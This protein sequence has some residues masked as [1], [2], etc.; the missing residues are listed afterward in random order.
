MLYFTVSYPTPD[1]DVV[2]AT[3]MLDHRACLGAL[4]RLR[5]RLG[6]SSAGPGCSSRSASCSGSPPCRG[7]GSR[8]TA[9]LSASSEAAAATLSVRDRGSLHLRRSARR[10]RHG[11]RPG[12]RD[13]HRLRPRPARARALP[14]R[15]HGARAAGRP[16][17]ATCPRSRRSSPSTT[18]GS[19]CPLT[20]IDQSILARGRDAARAGAR[21]SRRR[22]EVCAT[23]GDKYVAHVFFEEHGIPSPRTLAARARCRTTRATRCSS[24]CARASARGTSIAPPTRAELDVLPRATR[25]SSRWCRSCAS[26]RS[27]RSTS[28]ATSRGA[29]STRSRGR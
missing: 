19:S 14:R 2:K 4:L 24:R 5:P 20:D 15:P 25:R 6:C 13:H 1:G 29:A 10:H 12:R 8:S 9:R 18:S 23:M 26:A 27:S 16:I 17:P 21:C 22:Y 3:Y 11:I 7:S 28:S